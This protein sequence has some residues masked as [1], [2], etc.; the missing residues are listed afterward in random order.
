MKK[1]K[2]DLDGID[3]NAFSILGAFGSR[4]RREGWTKEE[5]AAVREKATA[6]DYAHLVTIIA[7]HCEDEE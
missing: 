4:A 5:I 2:L 7:E 6:G 1:I 3:G